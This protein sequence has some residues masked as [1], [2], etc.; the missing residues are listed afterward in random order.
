MR[1]GRH[2]IFK[3]RRHVIPADQL[4]AAAAAL[5]HIKKIKEIMQEQLC[6]KSAR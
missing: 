6:K 3:W 1:H 2:T 4:S 5:Q